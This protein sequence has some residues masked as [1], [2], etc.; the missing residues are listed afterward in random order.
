MDNPPRFPYPVG[1]TEGLATRDGSRLDALGRIRPTPASSGAVR[2]GTLAQDLG[3]NPRGKSRE[4]WT[5]NPR[6]A[7]KHPSRTNEMPADIEDD[8]QL[9]VG[10]AAGESAA[11]AKLYDRHASNMLGLAVRILGNRNE[12]EDLVHDVFIEAWQ[13]AEQYDRARGTVKAW[14][15]MRTR[16]R[17]LDRLRSA[18]LRAAS[19]TAAALDPPASAS[20]DAESLADARRFLAVLTPPQRQVIELRFFHGLSGR[21]ISERHNIPLGTVKARLAGALATMRAHRQL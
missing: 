9:L 10:A 3:C 2:S 1:Q 13:R 18:T 16:S 8:G 14:L 6:K 4:R 21:E 12:A 17:A 15:L 7:T 11:L 20:N 5:P 19:S